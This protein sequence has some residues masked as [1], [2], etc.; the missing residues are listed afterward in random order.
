MTDDSGI[1]I[2]LLSV[3][4]GLN[5]QNKSKLYLQ[6]EIDIYTQNSIMKYGDIILKNWYQLV[7]LVTFLLLSA[8]F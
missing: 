3:L 2:V 8:S 4:H 7:R 5:L 6:L 1:M